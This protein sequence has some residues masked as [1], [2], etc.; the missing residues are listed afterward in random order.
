MTLRR[1]LGAV[2]AAAAASALVVTGLVTTA[3]AAEDG[4]VDAGIT[5]PKVEGMGEGWIN[6]VDVSSVLSL[7]ESGVVFRD[8]SGAEAD[9]FEVLADHGVNWVRVRVWN[10]PWTADGNGYGGGNTDAD[11]ATEIAE[12]AT[13]AGMRVLVNF[14]YSDF[15]A[16]PGQQQLP[17]AWKDLD[18]VAERAVAVRAYTAATLQQMDDAGVDIGMVQIGNETTPNA[19]EQIVEVGGWDDFATVVSAGSAAVREVVPDA[20]VAVHFTNP[21]RGNHPS[22][23]AALDERG[24]DYD[25]FLSSYYPFWHGSLEDLTGSLNTIAQTYDKDVAVAEV[26]WAYTLEDGDGHQNTVRTP[27]DQY[28][29]SVQGQAL[30]IRDVMQAV[31]NVE[32][33]RGIGTFYWEPAWLPVGTPDQLESNQV[34]WEQYGSGWA[35]SYA[36]EYDPADAG[37]YYGGSSWDNQALFDFDGRPLESLKVYDY[38]VTG[39]VAP[40][41]VDSV[42]SPS[43]T[44]FDDEAVAL[45]SSVTVRYTDGTSE[46]AP[47]TWSADATWIAG[48]GLY[49]VVGATSD[50]TEVT[51][52]VEVL[53]SETTGENLVVNGGFEDADVSMWEGTGSGFTIGRAEDPYT[54]TQSTHW[55]SGSANS[56]EIAQ[57]LTD[58]PAGT[59]RLSAFLQGGGAGPDDAVT[60]YAQH[61]I[62]TVSAAATLEGYE[63]WQNPTTSLLSVSDG[64]T[65]DVWIEWD[66]SAGAWGTLDDVS[67]VLG[68]ELPDADTGALEALVDQAE[69]VDRDTYSAVSL[70]SLDRGLRRASFVLGSPAP[71]QLAVDGA[72]SQLQA[73]IDGLEEGDGTI[74]DPTVAPVEVVVVD[75]DAITLPDTVTVV[76]YD[77]STSTESVVWDDVLDAIPGPGVYA[78]AGVTENGWD[79]TAQITVTTRNWI[80]NAGFESGVDDVSPWSLVAD[81]WPSDDGSYWV[82][83]AAGS[84]GDEGA[85]ALNYYVQAEPYEFTGSQV[86]DL[87]AGTYRLEATAMGGSDAGGPASVTLVASVDGEEHAAPFTLSGW[88]TWDRQAIEFAVSEDAVTTVGVRGSADDG[89]WGFIDDFSLVAVGVDAADAS[90]LEDAIAQA[91]ALDPDLYTPESVAALA[92]A[93]ERGRIVLAATSA[94]KAVVDAAAAQVRA[95]VDGLVPVRGPMCEIDYA[96]HGQWP[97]GFISQVWITNVSDESIDGWDLSWTFAGDERVANLWGGDVDQDGAGVAVSSL[98]WNSTIDPG[99]R[100]TFGFVGASSGGALPLDAFTMNG[101]ACEVAP[102]Q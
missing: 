27:Y 36:G 87:P 64:G 76:A 44:V 55:Y 78:V 45:P 1:R 88:P 65:V 16:H 54:G 63:V 58:V 59:Y 41:E 33:G 60:L 28:S 81:P 70:L 12:R 7:E 25:V 84:E 80:A 51:A 32:N 85:F 29:I 38:A 83:A 47:V 93:T 52:T 46:A 100:I 89:D 50:G 6:G 37:V 35:S 91:E 2:T 31:A 62:S 86:I 8:D 10:D 99:E 82:T 17:K 24:V 48:P 23:A 40:R 43:I 56:F 3:S 4:P 102:E 73:A 75:G 92:L 30:A 11:R 69:A 13:A 101:S 61:G 14:H 39:S 22:F 53:S 79:A 57:T 71:S 94:T 15:W 77:D 66:L 96:V 20:Q 9:L 21:E 34:L 98:P 26:S 68:A 18:T 72:V 74:P 19:S 67:F 42:S 5:V 95:A 49:T 97:G 90:A